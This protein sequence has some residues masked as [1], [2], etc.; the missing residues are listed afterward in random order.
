MN[1][2]LDPATADALIGSPYFHAGFRAFA[3]PRGARLY[4][5]PV[6]Q[7]LRV[8]DTVHWPTRGESRPR[9]RPDPDP[10]RPYGIIGGVS[11]MRPRPRLDRELTVT[12]RTT[13]RLTLRGPRGVTVSLRV[14]NGDDDE[15]S[16]L[17]IDSGLSGRA[18]RR[19]AGYLEAEGNDWR[20]FLACG[21]RPLTRD[22]HVDWAHER[23]GLGG[24][25][26]E[27]PEGPPERCGFEVVLL[28]RHPLRSHGEDDSQTTWA[29]VAEANGVPIAPTSMWW[30]L[31]VTDGARPPQDPFDSSDDCYGSPG[32]GAG[33]LA[34]I[35]GLFDLLAKQTS[36]PDVAFGALYETGSLA[37]GSYG[38]G[39]D[40][41]VAV[42]T[43]DP[44]ASAHPDLT[45]VP[46]SQICSPVV[47]ML[48]EMK[49][50][51]LAVADVPR[52]A[53]LSVG[54]EHGVDALWPE[55]REWLL[56]TDIDWPFTYLGCDRTTADAVRAADG[57]EAVELA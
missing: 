7:P 42:Y 55:G 50:V 27:L 32:D 12:V 2:P 13:G 15:S 1:L 23:R 53:G 51:P 29:D 38:P 41:S 31:A 43:T 18:T 11:W 5:L 48:R 22:P 39:T 6:T 56:M 24:W 10:L 35:P 36:T 52:M 33:A 9:R 20:H 47:S 57:I 26:W 45:V 37:W 28:L 16:V 14:E 54:R 44:D 3:H 8:G 21:I 30:D 46:A 40:H 34:E 25:P 17:R 19:L 49:V 4:R